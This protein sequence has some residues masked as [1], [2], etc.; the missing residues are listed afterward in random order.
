MFIQQIVKAVSSGWKSIVLFV[1]IAVSIS[2]LISTTTIPM[3]Q[4]SATFVIAPNKDLP[5]SRDVVSAFTALDTLN[6]FSTYADILASK[7]VVD[8]ANKV[9]GL[10]EEDLSEYVRFTEIHPDSIILELSIN[11][12]D[13][14]T[15]AYLANEMGKYGIRF[16]NAY[17]SIFEIDFLDQAVSANVPFKPNTYRDAI[18]AAGIGFGIGLI[19]VVLKEITEIPLN[20]FIQRFS[21]DSESY[22]LSKITILRELGKMKM[23]NDKWPINFVLIK[24]VN[25]METYE[26]LPKYARKEIA[27]E[28]VRR[29]KNQVK[30]SD[31]IGRWN[32]SVFAVVLPKTP[33]KVIPIIV[34]NIKKEMA[35]PV[36]FGIENSEQLSLTP[37]FAS[38]TSRN[39]VDFETLVSKAESELE[40][41]K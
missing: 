41:R 13:P 12:P 9:V 17:Y 37:V 11:G 4:S 32:D 3:Y 8:E 25:F 28:I 16:I 36:Y 30:G 10:S 18:L 7:R 27:V 1:L 2:L 22:A 35:S 24:M 38:S 21:L 6:I 20:R 5:S 19:A 29:L 34:E 15:A 26:I 23:Q 14:E 31:L 33:A 40:I 39:E